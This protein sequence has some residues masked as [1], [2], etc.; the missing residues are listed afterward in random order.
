MAWV[1]ERMARKLRICREGHR[2][3]S[4]DP[5]YRRDVGRRLA[6]QL[7]EPPSDMWSAIP[8]VWA[9][10]EGARSPTPSVAAAADLLRELLEGDG[11]LDA[12]ELRWRA[13]SEP[14]PD[15][16][17]LLRSHPYAG[18]FAWSHRPTSPR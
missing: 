12:F 16:G 6:E 8:W 1:D 4:A 14:R 3:A 11:P 2:I 5:A 13:L 7:G 10:V 17:S 9:T 15:L 18:V